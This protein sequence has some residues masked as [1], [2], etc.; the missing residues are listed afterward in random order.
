MIARESNDDG[1]AIERLGAKSTVEGRFE[2]PGE[3]NVDPA[4]RQCFHLHRRAHFAER[5]FDVGMELAIL[6]DDAGEEASCAPQ[7]EADTERADLA[8]N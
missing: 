8:E 3:G 6:A 4:G 1:I 5:K 7:K 2:R